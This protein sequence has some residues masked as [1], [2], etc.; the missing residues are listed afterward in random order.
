[1][2]YFAH[3]LDFLGDPYFVAGTAV[4]DWLTVADRRVRLRRRHLARAVNHPDPAL[5]A[6]ARGIAQHLDD[7]ARFHE[8]RA[9]VEL[10]MAISAAARDF[11][12]EPSGMR[13]AFLGHLL[14]EVLLDASL[15][16]ANPERLNDYYRL[17]EQAD[18]ARV[19]A[20]VNTMAPEPTERLAGMMVAF[21]RERILWDY[22]HDATLLRRLNQVMRR[23]GLAALP[24]EFVDLLPALRGLVD[25]RSAAL[26]GRP[27][28]GAVSERLALGSP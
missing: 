21:C 17:L 19:E 4:P 3:A 8:S 23:V 2:N 11:L 12:H 13:P 7:D 28:P 22:L 6:L 18:P 15:I 14:V 25:R 9:F 20:S 26:L 10:S 24:A 5:S 27:G 1:M 16:A